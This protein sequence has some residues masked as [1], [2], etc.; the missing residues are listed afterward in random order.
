MLLLL[1]EEVPIEISKLLSRHLNGAFDHGSCA[2]S[3]ELEI[4]NQG[5]KGSENIEFGS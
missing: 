3:A 2:R 1:V 5:F 4:A